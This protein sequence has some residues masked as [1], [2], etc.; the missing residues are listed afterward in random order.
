MGGNLM[1]ATPAPAAALLTELT[2]HGIELQARGDRLR[3]RPQSAMTP[4]LAERVRTHKADLLT[5]LQGD[6]APEA[7]QSR[8]K[9]PTVA[10]MPP[11]RAIDR[12]DAPEGEDHTDAPHELSLAER[13]ESGYV[14]P[15]WT[16]QAWTDRLRQLA[17]RCQPLG[18]AL[19]A[20]YRTWAANVERNQ[21]R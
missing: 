9:R 15:G 21:E 3:Y 20:Q 16:A 12:L 19:A 11:A 1:T 5:L 18:P 7:P 14:N 2:R 17:D 10:P 4:E 8:Q 13:V 6:Q